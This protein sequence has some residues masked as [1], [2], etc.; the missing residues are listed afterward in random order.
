M[1]NIKKELQ[2]IIPKIR[3]ISL[4]K[5]DKYFVGIAVLFSIVAGSL[6][7]VDLVRPNNNEKFT[8]IYIQDP[9]FLSQESPLNLNLNDPIYF[10]LGIGNNEY[11]QTEYKLDIRFDTLLVYS[12]SFVLQQGE[13]AQKQIYFSALKGGTNEKLQILLYKNADDEVYRSLHFWINVEE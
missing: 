7:I 4:R 10:T 5:G 6:F 13:T 3:G 9:G 8:E 11:E 1:L 12:E 2:I